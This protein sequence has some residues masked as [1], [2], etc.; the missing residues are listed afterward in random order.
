VQP[1]PEPHNDLATTGDLVADNTATHKALD[2]CA[3][4]VE[5]LAA[6]RKAHR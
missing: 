5:Q 6:W 4:K 3:A 2:E 1:C